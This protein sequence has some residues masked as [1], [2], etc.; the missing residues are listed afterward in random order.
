[1]ARPFH[2]LRDTEPA[3][4]SELFA[5][6]SSHPPLEERIRRVDPGWNGE[7][8]VI[9]RS[10]DQPAMAV[11]GA[12]GLTGA[13]AAPSPPAY[14]LED[15]YTL[16]PGTESVQAAVAGLMLK[17]LTGRTSQFFEHLMRCFDWPQQ[18]PRRT[19]D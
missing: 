2:R 12:A 5:Y 18:E 4:D 15:S 16:A 10:A 17:A 13:E 7:Y 9:E 19:K 11:A 14:G 3:Q 6:L 1:M 8:P